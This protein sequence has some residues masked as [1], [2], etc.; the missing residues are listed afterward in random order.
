M[1]GHLLGDIQ[2]ISGIFQALPGFSV[3][4]LQAEDLLD[5]DIEQREGE[6]IFQMI[7]T[8]I[9]LQLQKILG[10]PGAERGLRTRI[11]P[12]YKILDNLGKFPGI[13]VGLHVR[14]EDL[15]GTMMEGVI[16]FGPD[17]LLEPVC[18]FPEIVQFYGSDL[19]DL[20]GEQLI[21]LFFSAGTL[22]PFQ[23]KNN[24]IHIK[25]LIPGII[26]TLSH[27]KEIHLYNVP[28]TI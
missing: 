7:K 13:P 27:K 19:D 24:I 11:T 8:E 1:K 12:V 9:P 3:L 10:S 2:K 23:V 14:T 6:R 18:L 21:F 26:H 4:K 15:L 22:V 16:D 28:D 17:L 20:E 5:I 25:P